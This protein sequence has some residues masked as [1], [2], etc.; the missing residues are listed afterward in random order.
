[1][2]RY[3][4]GRIAALLAA[5]SVAVVAAFGVVALITGEARRTA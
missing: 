2:R 3:R 4:F 1:V 5:A